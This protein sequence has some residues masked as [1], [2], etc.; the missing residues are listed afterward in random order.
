MAVQPFP[1]SPPLPEDAELAHSKTSEP[2]L[3]TF[4]E[5]L[6]EILSIFIAKVGQWRGWSVGEVCWRVFTWNNF[7]GPG[8]WDSWA[9]TPAGVN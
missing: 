3:G 2:P 5:G 8:S 9:G 6:N 4:S 7:V 1:S